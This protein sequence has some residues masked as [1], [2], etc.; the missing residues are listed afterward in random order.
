MHWM[1]CLRRI[2]TLASATRWPSARLMLA[3]RL[4]R[5]SNIKPALGGCLAFA[6][7][8]E[9]NGGL[10]DVEARAI[11]QFVYPSAGQHWNIQSDDSM[12]KKKRMAVAQSILSS[13]C[14]HCWAKKDFVETLSIQNKYIIK[15]NDIQ[16][17]EQDEI[18]IFA[19]RYIKW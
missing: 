2:D 19:V 8:A 17:N 18:R 14:R 12:Q 11:K 10:D 3:R 6:W 15:K 7:D 5:R 4:R 1:R 13:I 9:K 16:N